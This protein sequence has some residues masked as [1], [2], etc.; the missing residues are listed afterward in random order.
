MYTKNAYPKKKKKMMVMMMMMTMMMMVMVLVVVKVGIMM[1]D[2]SSPPCCILC[3][4]SGPSAPS[5][6]SGIPGQ[7]T[8]NMAKNKNLFTIPSKASLSSFS[9]LS[10]PPMVKLL[11]DAP[12]DFILE[13]TSLSS[14]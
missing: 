13:A 7:K 6:G 9:P 4:L 11:V 1:T 14:S 8:S 12:S 3:P 2:T 5:P 10:S